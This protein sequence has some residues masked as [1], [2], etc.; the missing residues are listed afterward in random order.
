MSH[1][2]NSVLTATKKI[3]HHYSCSSFVFVFFSDLGS[4][5]S[6]AKLEEGGE[7]GRG[8]GGVGK[9]GGGGHRQEV[10]KKQ[11]EKKV[12]KMIRMRMKEKKKKEK[13]KNQKKRWRSRRKKFVC[14]LLNVPATC[15]CISGTDLNRHFYVLPNRDRNCRSNGLPHPVTVY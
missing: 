4:Y 6:S 13:R 2:L 14:W 15:K 3:F 9:R 11:R 5:A 12:M 8:G 1:T 7:G 10:K